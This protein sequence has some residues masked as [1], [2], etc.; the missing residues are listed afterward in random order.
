MLGHI[1]SICTRRRRCTKLKTSLLQKQTNAAQMAVECQT[2]AR[3]QEPHTNKPR[4][5]HLRHNHG[6]LRWSVLCRILRHI[7]RPL[8]CSSCMLAVPSCRCGTTCFPLE[9]PM[10]TC[11]A[12]SKVCVHLLSRAYTLREQWE[13]KRTRPIYTKYCG[14]R[15]SLVVHFLHIRLT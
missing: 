1:A 13:I 12:H 5:V 6:L 11:A 2:E 4:G 8:L 10:H 14:R 9:K 3:L 7:S 15:R